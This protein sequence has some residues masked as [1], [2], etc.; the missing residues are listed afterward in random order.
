MT[1]QGLLA[2]APSV[3]AKWIYVAKI[4]FAFNV[5]Q[6]VFLQTE[7]AQSGFSLCATRIQRAKR[8]S[9]RIRSV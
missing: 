5:L 9:A 3:N 1:D 7:L 4:L 6:M 2:I 8:A